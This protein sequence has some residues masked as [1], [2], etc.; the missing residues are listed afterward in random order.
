MIV[1]IDVGIKNLSFCIL[2]RDASTKI[3]IHDW[4]ILDLSRDDIDH[5]CCHTT[6]KGTC[7]KKSSYTIGDKK[8]FCGT[9]IKKCDSHC[10]SEDYYKAKKKINKTI[11]DRLCKTYNHQDRETVLQHIFE[12]SI[13]RLPKS[14]SATGLDIVDIGR[15]ISLKLSAVIN[16]T[17]VH[18]VLIEN[19]IG[20][21]ANRMKCVQGMI[22]QFFIERGIYDIS[23][24]SSSNKLRCYD[25]PKKT[26][27]ERKHSG[28]EITRTIL[29][30]NSHLSEWEDCFNKH[31]K[32][33]DLADS[34]LQ[35]LWFINNK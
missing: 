20:P 29:N 8:Y 24:I 7:G 23:F 34:L 35:G 32:R 1:S 27:K 11:I 10:A 21:I 3:Q 6:K 12:T 19:Q 25:V 33:D 9:H 2:S 31:K 15:A 26:Y 28:I 17:N 5:A 18:K 13:T 22:A 4:G 14:S 16:K 30:E